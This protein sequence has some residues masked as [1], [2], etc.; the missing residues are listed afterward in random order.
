MTST[1][2]TTSTIETACRH[3]RAIRCSPLPSRRRDARGVPRAGE[4]GRRPQRVLP[5]GP[6][7]PARDRLPRRGR[8]RSWAAGGFPLCAELA[9]KP[10]S[11][12]PRSRRPRRWR[13]ACT[14]TGSASPSSTNARRHLVPLDPR[15]GRCGRRLRR[16]PRRDRQRRPGGHVDGDRGAGPG[17]Y[18][19][20]A[21]RCSARTGRS[22][23]GLGV[24]ALDASDPER[25]VIVHGFVRATPTASPSC[26]NWDTLGMRPS[27]SYDTVLDDVFVPDERIGAIVPAGDGAT[28]SS[29]PPWTVWALGDDR[30]VYLGI[31]ER[32]LELAVE[33]ATTKTSVAIPRGYLRTQ[34]DGAAPD[35]RDVPRARRGR[36]TARPVQSTTS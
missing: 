17:G 18:R 12:R 14:T 33:S 36:P 34:P 4:G 15:A 20:T 24:H 25:P 27:Q 1:T 13:C 10:A 28:T 8:A 30:N 32:A 19:F 29:S 31:A 26:A 9:A 2:S 22:G 5:R 7:R 35:R 6:R 21:T 16:R 11:P 23:R 3:H